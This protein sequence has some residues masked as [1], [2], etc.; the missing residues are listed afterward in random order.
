MDFVHQNCS[1]RVFLV[2]NG[3]SKHQYGILYIRVSLGTKIKPKLRSLIFWTNFAQKEYFWSK[4]EKKNTTMKFCL[5]ELGVVS[6][7]SLNWQFWL[8][9]PN[10]FIKVFLRSKTEKWHFCVRPWWLLTMLNF[11]AWGLTAAMAF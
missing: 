7:F 11:S 8:F 9:G 2:S 10:L 4:A 1:K 5:F 6:N 3:K